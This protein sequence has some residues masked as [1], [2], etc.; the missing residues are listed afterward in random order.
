MA[1]RTAFL[2]SDAK[3][4]NKDFHHTW[5][6]NYMLKQPWVMFS[7][8]ST[9]PEFALGN[10]QI[11]WG[12][13]IIRCTRTTGTF[14]GEEILACFES[15]ATESISTSWNKKVF[16]EIPQVYVNDSTYYGYINLMSKLMSVRIISDSDYP[17]HTNYIPLWEISN[18]D[19]K[20]NRRKTRGLKK[21]SPTPFLTSMK[22]RR[23]RII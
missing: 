22:L 15:T 14:A 9:K 3:W 16:I 1:Q 21:R 8:Y 10:W 13:A 6:S 12:K 4:Y 20:R 7:N 11:A 2:N 18:G 19:G 5:I 23:G 17:S